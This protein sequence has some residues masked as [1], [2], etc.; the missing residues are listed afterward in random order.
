[1]KLALASLLGVTLLATSAH[2]EFSRRPGS[3]QELRDYITEYAKCMVRYHH[4][5]ARALIL[6][7]VPNNRLE[8][9]FGSIYTPR[10][11][12]SVQE[13]ERLFIRDGVAFQLQPDTFRGALAQA[14]VQHDVPQADAANFADRAPLSHWTVPAVA[15]GAAGK[16]S[17]QR[18]A[19]GEEIGRAWLAR[20]GECLV[21]GNARAS[22][23][24]ILAKP[25]SAEEKAAVAELNPVFAGCLAQ[26]E[27]MTFGTAVLRDAVA[28]NYYR[29]A[30][31]APVSSDGVA[32]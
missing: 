23:G 17:T 12:A 30:M 27:T 5:D 1:M 2:A 32:H 14:L 26:G 4:A 28:I 20:Y 11:L 16:T 25:G 9:D 24:W 7:D 15:D 21:R 10:P 8:R 31:A 13:C 22:H 3:P 6:S 29:L 19:L 18:R